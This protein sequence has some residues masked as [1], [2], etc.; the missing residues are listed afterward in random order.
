MLVELTGWRWWRGIYTPLKN[1]PV[2]H[3]LDRRLRCKRAGDSGVNR[4]LRPT[5]E[6]LSHLARPETPVSMGAETPAGP[7]TPGSFRYTSGGLSSTA[8][9]LCLQGLDAD[10][11]ETPGS[12]G[13]RLRP[14]RKLR[15]PSGVPPVNHPV[16]HHALAHGRKIQGPETPALVGRRL[17]PEVGL[18]LENSAK[19]YFLVVVA[20]GKI[21]SIILQ[22][23]ATH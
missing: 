7:E 10:R 14:P 4:R 23:L 2:G 3:H 6:P 13:R 19:T 5:S 8:P 22:H 18:Q 12:R 21:M 16:P 20:Q 1:L 15:A 17:Q 11:P 9:H